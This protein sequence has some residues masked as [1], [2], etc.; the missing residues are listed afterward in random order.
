[1]IQKLH[2]LPFL[3]IFAMP[4]LSREVK[5]YECDLCSYYCGVKA[6][7]FLIDGIELDGEILW[8]GAEEVRILIGGPSFC[9]DR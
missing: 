6:F 5:G 4:L 7:D 9:P 1:M 8:L 2:S 3:Y